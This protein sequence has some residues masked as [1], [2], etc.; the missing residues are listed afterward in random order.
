MSSDPDLDRL[1]AAVA[2]YPD[3]IE[4]RVRLIRLLAGR[5]RTADALVQAGE[6]L[7]LDPGNAEISALVGDLGAQLSA[8]PAAP[9]QFDWERAESE[10]AGLVAPEYADGAPPAPPAP[11]SPARLAEVAGMAE[12]KAQIER[13]F[14]G[15]LRNPDLA[16][17][18][19][20]RAGGGLLL[21][22]PPGCG[23]TFIASAIAGELGA[24]FYPV[25]VPDVVEMATGATDQTLQ[26][27]FATA[28]ATAPAV[29]FFDEIDAIGQK[30]S[31][32]RGATVLRQ[33]V[34]R[35]LTELDATANDGVFVL[36][37]SNHPWDVDTALRRPGRLDRMLFVSPP[38]AEARAAL[39][40]A[41]FAGKPIAGIDLA[42]MVAT[43]AGFSGADVAFLCRSAAQHAMSAAAVTGQPRY[44]TMDDVRAARGAITPSTG[45]WFAMARNVIE[46]SNADGAFDD[47]AAYLNRK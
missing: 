37:A 42:E 36:G 46:F 24:R 30:R 4:L 13:S 23:K 15:P 19:G 27:L 7:R 39:V 6:A 25:G 26:Q 1:A 9:G 43:T 40:R 3:V 12:V 10:V 45:P 44:I 35:L 29:I 31:L 11:R 8:A 2:D 28:R 20:T 14:I 32:L 22:G 41:N 5:G 18:Y 33:L 16:R 38:D 34:T 17:A 47:L 21:Y